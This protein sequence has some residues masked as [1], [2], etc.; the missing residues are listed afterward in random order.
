M[1]YLSA[2]THAAIISKP[3]LIASLYGDNWS[4]FARDLGPVDVGMWM[5]NGLL[6]AAYASVVANDMKPY[7]PETGGPNIADELSAPSLACDQFARLTWNFIKL[8]SPWCNNLKVRAVGWDNG[9][10][11]YDPP[12]PVGNHAQM[13]VVN[14][15]GSLLLDPTIGLVVPATYT[16]VA[17]GIPVDMSKSK[18]FCLTFQNDPVKTPFAHRV[19]DALGKGLYRPCHAL[20]YCA[21]L[22]NFNS[23][24]TWWPTPAGAHFQT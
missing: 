6:A 16:Q 11:T 20:Y 2:A 5:D 22:S 21:T 19:I 15:H 24:G 7:G 13:F 17:G 18:T 23:V 4:S 3:S 10:E 14:S 1:S 9:P 8:L 12:C